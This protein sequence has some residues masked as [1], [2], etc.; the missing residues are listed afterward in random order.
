MMMVVCVCTDEM[1]YDTREEI[2]QCFVVERKGKEG[3]ASEV[4]VVV[5]S[6]NV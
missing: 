1:K 6:P 5:K 4:K 3:F 2:G